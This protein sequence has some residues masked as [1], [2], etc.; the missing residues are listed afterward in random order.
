M[1]FKV[2]FSEH[3]HRGVSINIPKESNDCKQKKQ[4]DIE[5]LF[6]ACLTKQ[7]KIKFS[8]KFIA[9][10]VVQLCTL[11]CSFVQCCEFCHRVLFEGKGEQIS[12]SS[13]ML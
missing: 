1:N 10:H 11:L 8:I 13:S 4:R 9:Q 12:Y 7:R 3:P 2:V 5:T 6:F